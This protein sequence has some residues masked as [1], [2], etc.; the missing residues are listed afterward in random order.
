MREF[1]GNELSEIARAGVQ[2]LPDADS[3]CSREG[4]CRRPL[5]HLNCV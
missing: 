5:G 1:E 2:Q 4:A 3:N